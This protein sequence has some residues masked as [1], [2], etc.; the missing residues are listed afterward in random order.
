[1]MYVAP[2]GGRA[3][4]AGDDPTSFFRRRRS[5]VQEKS[6]DTSLSCALQATSVSFRP[7]KRPETRSAS[8][9]AGKRIAPPGKKPRARKG[10][11]RQD[12]G[13]VGRTRQKKRGQ[14]MG[15]GWRNIRKDSSFRPVR[16]LLRKRRS[17]TNL[18]K[19]PRQSWPPRPRRERSRG[20]RRE[21]PRRRS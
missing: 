3:F 21:A 1:M 12:K 13:A 16:R 4:S 11:A 15:T 17:R 9:C 18:R 19:V 8:R 5:F 10:P 20:P 14:R 7:A 2:P 6:N